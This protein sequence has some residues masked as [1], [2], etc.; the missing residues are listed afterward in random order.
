MK[1]AITGSNGYVGN[2]LAEYFSS[3]GIGVIGL[4][5]GSMKRQKGYR[6]FTFYRCDVRDRDLV[7]RVMESERPTHVCHLAYLMDPQHNYKFEYDVD[8]NG[9]KNVFEA[10]NAVKSVKQFMHFSSASVYGAFSDN[11]LWI[12]E[13]QETTPRDWVYAQNKCIVEQF[14]LSYPKRDDMNLVNLRMC[15][16]VGPSYYKKGGVVSILAKSPVG[17]L[18]DGRDTA[19][20]FIH[21]DDV[22]KLVSLIVD[23]PEISGTYN[24]ASDSYATTRDLCVSPKKRFISVPKSSF[25]AVISALWH[26]RLSSV[27]PTSVNLVAHDIVVSP[28]KLVDRYDYRFLYST[29]EAFFDAYHERKANG[30]I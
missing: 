30:T 10:A 8:V 20:Q 13:E 16:A 21:E 23:D 24:L 17:L 11:G 6:N 27:S 18:L 2:F 25:K 4:D 3:K 15:T 14:Y 19:L 9:S 29:Q 26:T 12:K 22:K 5:I 1:I 28:K 7:F